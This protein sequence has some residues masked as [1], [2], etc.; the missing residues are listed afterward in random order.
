MPNWRYELIASSRLASNSCYHAFWDT[1]TRNERAVRAN[2]LLQCG[3]AQL[4]LI[5]DERYAAIVEND[6]R[7]R[8]PFDTVTGKQHR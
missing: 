1:K 8:A 5:R 2:R 4:V 7:G 3:G 6:A